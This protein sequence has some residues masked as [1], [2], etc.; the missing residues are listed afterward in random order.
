MCTSMNSYGAIA[1][2]L[3]NP[4]IIINTLIISHSIDRPAIGESC[5]VQQQMLTLLSLIF[6]TKTGNISL[7]VFPSVRHSV[8]Y[9]YRSV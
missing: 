9:I 3:I 6:G 7:K 2:A 1:L 5:A 8:I 4:I